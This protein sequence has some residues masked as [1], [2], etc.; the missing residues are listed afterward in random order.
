MKL[1]LVTLRKRAGSEEVSRRE[2][3]I[4]HDEVRIGRGVTMEISLPDLDVDFHHATVTRAD[5][6]LVVTAVSEGGLRVG[7]RKRTRVSLGAGEEARIGRYRFRAEQGRDGADFV[8]VMEEEPPAADSRRFRVGGGRRRIEEVLPSRRK[9]SWALVLGMLGLFVAWPMADVLTREAPS[10]D[11]VVT[12]G[13]AR[14]DVP[15]PSPMEIAWSSGP[16][17]TSHAMIGND[18]GACHLRPFER[19]PNNAC[20]S[21]HAPIENHSDPQAHPVVALENTRCAGCHQEHNGGAAPT[22]TA[23]TAC[24]SCHANIRDVAPESR[25]PDIHGFAAD[26]PPFRMAVVVDVQQ[27][28]DGTLL[29]QIE[30]LPFD[31][32]NPPSEGSGLKFPHAKHLAAGGVMSP[33]G[34]VQLQCASCHEQEPGGGLMQPISFEEDCAGC[35]RMTFNAAGTERPLPHAEEDEVAR[36][37]TDYFIAAA[38]EGGVTTPSAPEP[39]K[40]QRRRIAGENTAEVREAQL[41]D[42]DRGIAINWAKQEAVRQMDVIFGTRLCGTCHEARKFEDQTGTARW[43]V[44]PAVLQRHW[45]PRARF[46]HEPHRVMDCT[47]CHEAPG[48]TRA[49]DILMPGIATCQDCHQGEGSPDGALTEC[50]SCHEY[51]I[52]GRS[53]MSPAHAAM[54]RARAEARQQAEAPSE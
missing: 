44:L 23:S 49:S 12:D 35:H 41:S 36:I 16:L 29:P 34:E 6:E 33:A 13:M 37:V 50:V 15:D 38:L 18:C 31:P 30:R 7:R 17:S 40:R 8:L 5:G 53:P 54:F 4:D 46:D 3:L 14:T 48:S 21:C 1:L 22:E 24:A 27:E 28:E 32:Q 25:L 10:A 45:M 47:N 20:L 19:V 2:T 9:L 51:H 39:V 11:A 26:H 42:A 52:P 43:R